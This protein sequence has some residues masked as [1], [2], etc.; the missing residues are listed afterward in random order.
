[1][2]T[3]IRIKR[4]G[5]TTSPVTLASGELAYT[6][7]ASTG[8]K[9]FLGT[10][11]EIIPGQ[12][13][14]IDV[15][16]GKYFTDMLDHT[17]GTLTAGSAIIVDSNS[18]IN[19]LFVDN[20]SVDG[21]TITTTNTN[22]NLVFN[23]NGTGVFDFSGK[24]ITNVGA[25][26][27]PTDAVTLGY[28]TQ[29]FSSNL[30]IK[31]D[32]GTDTITLS[33]E[34]LDFNG[35]TGIATAVTANTVTFNLTDTGVVAGVYGSATN[36]PVFTVDAQGRL[37]TANTASIATQLSIAGDS[38][39]DS[40]SLLTDTLTVTGGTAL[41]SAVTNNTITINLD[42]TAVTAGS[43]GSANTVST[44]TVDAQGRLTAAGTT[45]IAIPAARVTDFTEAVQDVVGAFT[46]GNAT[47]GIT[48]TYT[49]ASNTLEISASDASTTQKGVASFATADFNVTS[50]AVELKDTV[51]K[52]ITT[53]S[54]ALTIASHAVSILGGEGVDVTHSGTTI[55]IAGEDATTTN[56]G[57]ASFADANFTVTTGA[58]AAKSITLG[59]STLSL[60]STTTAIAGITQLDVDNIR[61]DGNSISTTDTAGDINITPIINGDV[62]ITTTGTS[63]IN[64]TVPSGREITASTLAVSDLTANR[65]VY[66][67]TSGALVDDAD[68][69]FDGTNLSLTGV[70]NV[71][72]LRLDGNTLSSTDTNGNIVLDP[73]GS[74]VIDVSTA[75]I[76]NLGAPSAATDA[77]T[78][79]YVDTLVS[80]AIHYHDPVRVESPISLSAVYN[81]GTSGVGATLTST[82]SEVLVIDGVTL[83]QNDRVLV[84][85]QANT[86][87]NGVY[88][89]S[90]T[91]SLSYSWVL[92]RTTDTDSYSPSDSGGL[93]RGD[94][95]Y[96]KEGNT[97]AGELYVMTTEG[98]IT[99]GTTPI[100]FSQI[101]SAQIYR[102]GEGLSLNGVTFNVNVDNSSIEINN[103]T[104]RVKAAGVTNAMLAGGITNDKLSNST[105]TIAAETGS[106]DPVSLG[107]TITFAAG[108]G[109]DTVV[110]NNTITI[111]GEDATSSNKGI[112]SF[113]ATDF[114]VT[115]G[116][117]TINAERVQDIVFNSTVEGEGID[118]SYNDVANTFVISGED[119]T[120]TNKGI[121]SFGG[122]ANAANTVRQFSLTG[123]DVTI[124]NL[125]GGE[126]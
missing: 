4:S 106:P 25:P 79:T 33:S 87:H 83:S 8:G 31:G 14:N 9:L 94:S 122:W 110:S 80:A 89:T 64:F 96:V 95:F 54:G 108:E 113:D 41:T 47:Q 112:A 116:N 104:L 100:N 65:I 125:D 67:G 111:S 115:S 60:G 92:T 117:V 126:Y 86:V 76:T 84:Y 7:A 16:G 36:I 17:P 20:I 29:T 68:L 123:G 3:T 81:N 88:F 55:T 50:G 58:V 66:V 124:I 18:K 61:I 120:L 24:R 48:V 32:S 44:F 38:G 11:S 53:D 40:V 19:Q 77:V 97:G 118:I 21:N 2:G 12:A 22:G 99:L 90:N 27:N 46:S 121:A 59:T 82:A 98:T 26:T 101:S 78:K 71:D 1:M 105:I 119:A 49:D 57:I 28:L 72:N 42:N 35:G 43:Y 70:L 74:G 6:W 56:K 107:Q 103:D 102:A 75:R 10:G 62:N 15:I 91:G 51:L 109:I 63:T 73:N 69:T 37:T 52:S 13:P 34:T 5:T 45:N 23:T 39:T 85:Q 30:S 93:G 114:T